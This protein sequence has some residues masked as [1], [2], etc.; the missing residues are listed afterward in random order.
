[1]S[2]SETHR[3]ADRISSLVVDAVATAAGTEPRALEPPLYSAVDLDA[4][5]KLVG[6]DPSIRVAFEYDGRSVVVRGGGTVEVDGTVYEPRA[7]VE[8][9]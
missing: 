6:R 3:D 7:G 1:M 5:D 8:A 9:R 2:L 4:L